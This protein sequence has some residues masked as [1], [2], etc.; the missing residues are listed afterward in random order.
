MWATMVELTLLLHKPYRVAYFLRPLCVHS[1]AGSRSSVA[2][3]RELGS[4]WS[5]LI[6]FVE[7]RVDS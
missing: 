2:H 7:E 5:A 4:S 1:H 3:R 6:V